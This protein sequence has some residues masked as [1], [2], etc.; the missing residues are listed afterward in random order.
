MAMGFAGVPH[1]R[2][3][4]EHTYLVKKYQLLLT[5]VNSSF[6]SCGKFCAVSSYDFLFLNGLFIGFVYAYVPQLGHT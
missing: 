1:I 2:A 5:K 3:T 6:M 4:W